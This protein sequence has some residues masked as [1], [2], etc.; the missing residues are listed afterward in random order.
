MNAIVGV[1]GIGKYRYY[2]D[3]GN[4]VAGA[5]AAMRDKWDRYLHRG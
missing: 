2:R 3:A 5:A 1:H 4:S